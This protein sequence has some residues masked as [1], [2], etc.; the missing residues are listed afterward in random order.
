M[1]A[2]ALHS[3]T[4]TLVA[5]GAMLA[6]MDTLLTT[7]QLEDLLQVDRVTIY[8]MLDDGR[9]QGF[10]FGSQWRFSREAIE[11]WL[12]AQHSNLE[13]SRAHRSGG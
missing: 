9:L 12:R 3:L 4:L 13:L 1:L 10:K 8:R 11:T 2:H 7:R 6:W 5:F